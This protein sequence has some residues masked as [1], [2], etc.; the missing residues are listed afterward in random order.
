MPDCVLPAPG[1][2]SFTCSDMEDKTKRISVKWHYF[3]FLR[4]EAPLRQLLDSSLTT[5]AR[6]HR[7]CGSGSTASTAQRRSLRT[8]WD[9]QVRLGTEWCV[10]MCLVGSLSLSPSRSLSLSLSLW[11]RGEIRLGSNAQTPLP[12]PTCLMKTVILTGPRSEFHPYNLCKLLCRRFFGG[13]WVEKKHWW[14]G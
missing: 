6:A 2:V 5:C 7:H 11:E 9:F 14:H 1:T 10:L 4:S 8:G 3:S 12:L 13:L